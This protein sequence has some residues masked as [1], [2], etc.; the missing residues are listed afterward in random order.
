[1]LGIVIHY[2]RHCH[3]MLERGVCELVH[4]F[5][6]FS[7]FREMEAL[8]ISLVLI[9]MMKNNKVVKYNLIEINVLVITLQSL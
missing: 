9:D 1:M 5:S 3:A 7:S 8:V 6:P 4:S 2:V